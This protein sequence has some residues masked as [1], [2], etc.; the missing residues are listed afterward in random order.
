M[1]EYP[2]PPKPKNVP[3]IVCSIAACSCVVLFVPILAAVLFPVFAQARE[4][5]RAVSCMSNEKQQA[6]A[7]LM[8]VQDYDETMPRPVAWMDDVMPYLKN[9]Q[10]FHCP[11]ISLGRITPDCGY[12]FD[13]RLFKQNLA[14]IFSPATSAMLYDST[15][16][17]RSA[18]DACKSL[19]TGVQIRHLADNIAFM[20]GHARS[21]DRFLIEDEIN[22]ISKNPIAPKVKKSG[23]KSSY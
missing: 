8:Y 21:F 17:S 2:S 9:E 11:S 4:K 15:D 18:A 20:D 12:A 6:L 14:D 7:V 22:N 3:L 10:V 1:Q 16:L 23:K 19:P 13:K 5:A